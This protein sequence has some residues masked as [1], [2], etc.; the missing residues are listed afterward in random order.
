MFDKP[1]YGTIEFYQNLQEIMNND[2]KW[3]DLAKGLSYAMVYHYNAPVNKSFY[4]KFDDAMIVEVAEVGPD[5]ERAADFK[6]SADPEVWNGIMRKEI[7]PTTAM[8]TGQV[9]AE[10]SQ[11]Q[12][13]KN[14]KKLSYLNDCLAE[15][16]ADF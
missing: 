7:N 12:L 16:D 14:V 5:E 3:L 11:I 1:K 6:F 2:A 9:K 10:G 4:L 8:M 15:M 13:L